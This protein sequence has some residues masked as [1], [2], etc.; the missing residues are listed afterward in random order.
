MFLSRFETTTFSPF[1]V[2][3]SFNKN[4]KKAIDQHID[5]EKNLKKKRKVSCKG[6]KETEAREGKREKKIAERERERELER[7]VR[8]LKA[9][10]CLD[11]PSQNKE[12]VDLTAM[13]SAI[14]FIHLGNPSGLKI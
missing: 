2:G 3:F 12:V 1:V 10:Y 14:F 8:V 13:I 9:F 4:N 5:T 11:R 7:G 6:R